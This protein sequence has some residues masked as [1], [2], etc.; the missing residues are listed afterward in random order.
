MCKQQ[1]GGEGTIDGERERGGGGEERER[2]R[3]REREKERERGREREG[4]RENY[5]S[6]SLIKFISLIHENET[7]VKIQLA[8][9]TLQQLFKVRIGKEQFPPYFTIITLNGLECGLVLA[10]Q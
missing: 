1:R 5:L 9:S 10:N 7:G 8:L 4:E 2:E 6:N 3:E